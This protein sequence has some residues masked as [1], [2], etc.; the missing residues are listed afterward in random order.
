MSVEADPPQCAR[1]LT[2]ESEYL[3]HQN[4]ALQIETQLEEQISTLTN[5]LV[6]SESSLEKLKERYKNIQSELAKVENILEST[7]AELKKEKESSS[8]NKSKIVGL[9]VQNTKYEEELRSAQFLLKDRDEQLDRLQSQLVMERIERQI[10]K[11]HYMDQINKCQFGDQNYQSSKLDNNNDRNMSFGTD[12]LGALD[13]S[14]VS[15]VRYLPVR[16]NEVQM[17][18]ASVQTVDIEL[19][20]MRRMS[21]K[22]DNI[23]SILNYI[24]LSQVI[25]PDLQNPGEVDINREKVQ[26]EIS[27]IKTKIGS[28]LGVKGVHGLLSVV[29]LVGS[30]SPEKEKP[31][32]PEQRSQSKD[33]VKFPLKTIFSLKIPSKEPEVRTRRQTSPD[34]SVDTKRSKVATA[35]IDTNLRGARSSRKKP[36]AQTHQQGEPELDCALAKIKGEIGKT[37]K[38]GQQIQASLQKVQTLLKKTEF[39]IQD[40]T[41]LKH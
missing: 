26:E 40:S 23:S 31:K 13:S 11:E 38:Q 22:R 10:E 5:S 12:Y 32:Q 3:D 41:R 30:K 4:L 8:K 17:V 16:S 24:E 6:S 19:S 34:G 2:L 27:R 28:V 7:L 18:S 20:H 39:A 33:S 37:K 21:T 15:P 29:G 1:C 25:K 9:E 14:P 35:R 36:I